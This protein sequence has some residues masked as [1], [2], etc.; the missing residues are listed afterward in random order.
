MTCQ[1]SVAKIAQAIF[2]R[3]SV[4]P[5]SAALKLKED[6]FLVGGKFQDWQLPK[7]TVTGT[8][9][10]IDRLDRFR[11]TGTGIHDG[12]SGSAVLDSSDRLVG[13]HLGAV[14]S[15]DNYGR[16]QRIADAIPI[17]LRNNIPMNKL[18]LNGAPGSTKAT[19]GTADPL[20]DKAPPATLAG[21]FRTNAKDGLTS[22]WIPPG[23][24]QMVARRATSECLTIRSQPS[25]TGP[26]QS[27]TVR[28]MEIH[29]APDTEAQLQHLATSQGKNAAQVVEETLARVLDRRAQFLEGVERGIAAAD[30]G[31]L[32][33]HA[34]VVNRIERL[35]QSRRRFAGRRKPQTSSKPS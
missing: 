30:R 33:D 5:S 14:P 3:L 19:S 16:A 10:D 25:D 12:F 29:L 11:F 8:Q 9:D 34:E 22:A 17:L 21:D 18:E 26:C 4:R 24:F 28:R 15:D 7:D 1:P 2:R 31:D 6:I 27:L 23:S 35:F 20:R 13:V 32:I